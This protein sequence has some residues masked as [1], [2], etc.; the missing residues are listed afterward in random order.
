M[1]TRPDFLTQPL[2][3]TTTQRSSRSS[4]DLACPIQRMPRS[5][6]PSGYAWASTVALVVLT[7]FLL[8]SR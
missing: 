4:I 3:H 8:I 5:R 2:S 1:K 6:G 7:V